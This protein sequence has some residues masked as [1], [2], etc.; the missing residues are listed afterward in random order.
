MYR[1]ITRIQWN[2]EAQPPAISGCIL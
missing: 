1:E 2:Y